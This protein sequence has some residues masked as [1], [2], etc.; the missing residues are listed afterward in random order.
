MSRRS[1]LD[2]F[3]KN[4]NGQYEY[5]GRIYGLTDYKN[6]GLKLAVLCFLCLSSVI[7]SG[8]VNA[9]GLSNTFYVIIPYISEVICLFSLCWNLARLLWARGVFR[10]YVYKPVKRGIPTSALALS[11]FSGIGLICSI[12]FILINGFENKKNWCIIYF[13]LKIT[14]LVF[15]VL[16]YKF[17]PKLEWTEKK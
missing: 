5:T 8:F 4:G 16:I 7:G 15:G 12:I 17:F 3:K 9:A 10:E 1:Y 11:I 13:T 2:D 6:M 14:D